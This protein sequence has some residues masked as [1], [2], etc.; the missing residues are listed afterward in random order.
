METAARLK[1]PIIAMIWEDHMYG[2][3]AW[4]QTNEFGRH[5]DLSFTNPDFVML[6]E[7]FGWAG[8][9]VERSQDLAAALA[10][11]MARTDQPSLIVLPIDY[12][13]NQLLSQ[14]L[15]QIACPI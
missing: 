4:K 8:T 10:D 6:A 5:T 1:L 2:L 12:R 15:G 13:E 7:A 3:I 14:R 11:A 9:R